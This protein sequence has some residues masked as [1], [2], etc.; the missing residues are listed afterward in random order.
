MKWNAV[1]LLA[2]L[3]LARCTAAAQSSGVEGD[4]RD[5][6][7]SII[8]I[9]PCGPHVC[10][11]LVSLSPHAPS[12]TD[13]HNP[14]PGQRSRALCELEIGSG[15]TLRDPDHAAG[16]TLYDPKSGKTYHGAM[17][18]ERTAEGSKLELRGYVGIPLFGASQTWTR[19]TEPVHACAVAGAARN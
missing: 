19:V 16:G 11:W 1:W 3:S 7:G 12:T 17:T 4:W 15:F 10:L 14:E 13:V 6:T 18:V 5:P 2:L 9:A 8:R